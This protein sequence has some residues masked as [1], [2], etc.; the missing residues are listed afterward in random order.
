MSINSSWTHIIHWVHRF[1]YNLRDEH[2][3]MDGGSRYSGIYIGDV[4]LMRIVTRL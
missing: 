1:V 4:E 3:G 2:I